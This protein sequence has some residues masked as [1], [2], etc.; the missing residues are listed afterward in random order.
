MELPTDFLGHP[1]DSWAEA[2]TILEEYTAPEYT[3][4][5]TKAKI[6]A[7]EL[8]DLREALKRKPSP[9][10][11]LYEFTDTELLEEIANRYPFLFL[12]GHRQ[13]GGKTK[14]ADTPFYVRGDWSMLAGLTKKRFREAEEC[15]GTGDMY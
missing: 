6:V 7:Q 5:H 4:P 11:P 2:L 14:T 15:L 12:V 10:K 13:H 1:I 3:A 9:T 8:Q